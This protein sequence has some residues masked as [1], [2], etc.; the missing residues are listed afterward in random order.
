MLKILNDF[1]FS[2]SKCIF[3]VPELDFLRCS[4]SS[5]DLKSTRQKLNELNG[6]P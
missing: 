4:V 1:K 5:E 6:F 2:H 3:N